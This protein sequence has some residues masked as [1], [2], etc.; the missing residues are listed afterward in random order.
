MTAAASGRKI[1]YFQVERCT[2]VCARW[3]ASPP[4]FGFPVNDSQESS[5][6]CS[7]YA[8]RRQSIA[9]RV[10]RTLDNQLNDQT[11]VESWRHR[12]LDA[13][14]T[15][16][17]CRIR[18]SSPHCLPHNN[19]IPWGFEGFMQHLARTR[20]PGHNDADWQFERFRNLLLICTEFCRSL[21]APV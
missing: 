16:P 17:T 19:Q 12:F 1:Q 20:E 3:W 4:G 5:E 18:S 2:F 8:D 6:T 7:G 10:A 13:R 14:H 21:R 15:F 9:R 11:A